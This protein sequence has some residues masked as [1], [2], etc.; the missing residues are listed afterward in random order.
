MSES[1]SSLHQPVLCSEVVELFSPLEGKILVDGTLGLGGHSEA[2]LQ[3]CDS[4]RIIG[5]DRDAEALELAS[6]RLRRYGTRFHAVH[7]NYSALNGHLETL[8]IQAVHGLLLDIGVSSL[9]LDQSDRGF[10]FRREGPLDMR[11]NRAAGETAAEWIARATEAQLADAIFRFGEE[12]YAK[13]IARAIVRFRESTTIEST[14]QLADIVRSAVPANYDH[15]RLDPATRSFQAIRM[16]LNDELDALRTG[17]D[18]G[19]DHLLI[20]GTLIVIS[21]HSLEDRI[22]K[23]FLRDKER[24]C[25]CPPKMPECVCGKQIEARILTKRPLTATPEEA[26]ANPRSRSAKLRAAVRLG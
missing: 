2:L 21:F 3:A 17:L 22:V 23:Q 6:Q 26:L 7:G 5:I 12:R 15:R 18:V 9:Q 11:M 19:F 1:T 16:V 8:S 10:S 20:G 14:A 25:V 24:A 4:V 13:S